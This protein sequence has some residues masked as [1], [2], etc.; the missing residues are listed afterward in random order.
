MSYILD[1]PDE[2]SARFLQH[3]QML[4]ISLG[5]ALLIAIP[6]GLLIARVP[7]LS[8]PVLSLL[9][10]IYTIPSLALL[11][12]LVPIVGIGTTPAIIALVAYAQLILVRNIVTGLHGVDRAAVEAAYGMGMSPRQVLTRVELPL[13]LPVIIAGI[14]IATVAIIGIASIAAFVAAGGL[15]SLL[16]DGVD[17]NKNDLIRAG[18]LATAALAL[19]ADILLRLV[20]WGTGRATRVSG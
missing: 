5:I 19:V 4:G 17:Q 3:L 7:A 18:A 10:V 9:S 16:F 1:H 11:A 2:V 14:R 12:L 15:G 8:T 6:L 13:A 20:E